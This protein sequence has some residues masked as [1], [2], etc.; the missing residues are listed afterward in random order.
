ML[1]EW[2]EVPAGV[3]HKDMRDRLGLD[4]KKIRKSA[5][6]VVKSIVDQINENQPELVVLSTH[7][8]KGV[9]RWMNPAVAEPVARAAGG[10]TLF[11]PRRVV[12]FV[13][14]ETGAVTLKN[15]LI[16]IDHKPNP[17]IAV[18]AAMELARAAKANYVHFTLLHVGAEADMPTLPLPEVAGWYFERK[19]WAGNVVEHILDV[20]EEQNADLIVMAT[21]GRHGFLDAVRGSTTERILRA[22]RCPLLAAYA[23]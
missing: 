7:Q 1:E 10:L 21:G 12:G 6:N 8:R 5:A 13:S 18:E 19:A 15:I 22:A 16:P 3:S 9:D 2:G 11:V 20:A 23:R 14:R 4:V 17:Q